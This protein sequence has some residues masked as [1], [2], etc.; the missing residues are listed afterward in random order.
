MNYIEILK[1][2]YNHYYYIYNQE[3][4]TTMVFWNINNKKVKDIL[5]S[6][7]LD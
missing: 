2:L 5:F 1:T 7:V 4:E 3:T 6:C